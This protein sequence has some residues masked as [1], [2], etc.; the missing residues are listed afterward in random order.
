METGIDRAHLVAWTEKAV[1]EED[2]FDAYNK[3]LDF[4]Q[5]HEGI[6]ERLTYPQILE[7]AERG[8]L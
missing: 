2:R 5:E 3:I 7:L 8:S 4:C 1:R 6:E